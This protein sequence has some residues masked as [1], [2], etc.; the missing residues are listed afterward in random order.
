VIEAF[1]ILA[2]S[3]GRGSRCCALWAFIGNSLFVTV[4]KLRWDTAERRNRYVRALSLDCHQEF[5]SHLPPF[6]ISSVPAAADVV[7]V[8]WLS[9]AFLRP[10]SNPIQQEH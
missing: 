2:A 1:L 9:K 10:G 5:T 6:V 4:T 8:Y 7:V 3:L